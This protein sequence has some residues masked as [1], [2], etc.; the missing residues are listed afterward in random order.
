MPDELTCQYCGAPLDEDE[1]F[2]HRTCIGCMYG[3]DID[4]ERPGET[5]AL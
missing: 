5:V 3:G 2:E 1:E 4:A